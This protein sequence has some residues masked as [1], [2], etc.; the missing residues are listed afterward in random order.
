MP[1]FWSAP[2][3]FEGTEERFTVK[4]RP[5]GLRGNRFLSWLP[6]RTGEQ[7]TAS[8]EV[9][10]VSGDRPVNVFCTLQEPDGKTHKVI[11]PVINPTLPFT[12]STLE[13]Y[14]VIKGEY[15]LGV[16][17]IS[18]DPTGTTQLGIG[19]RRLITLDAFSQ[20][21][22]IHNL[23]FVIFGG[24]VGGALAKLLG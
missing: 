2:I 11:E 20:D 24:L 7:F 17:L 5:N 19:N 13:R 10:R 6:F 23:V 18:M 4:A 8:I 22:A 1:N 9:K 21:V 15:F 14:L 16:W 3:E 12:R